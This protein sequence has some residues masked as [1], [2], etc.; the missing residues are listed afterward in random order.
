MNKFTLL[1]KHIGLGAFILSP[2]PLVLKE[3]LLFTTCLTLTCIAITIHF[4]TRK[5]KTMFKNIIVDYPLAKE[6]EDP[7]AFIMCYKCGKCGRQFE[8]GFMI[9]DGGTTPEDDE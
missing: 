3:Y 8:N 4:L 5:E 7:D 9:H 2:I 6:C 1:I